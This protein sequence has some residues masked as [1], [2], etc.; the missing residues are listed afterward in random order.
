LRPERVKLVQRIFR[1]HSEGIGDTR[2][3]KILNSEGVPTPSQTGIWQA[4]TIRKLITGKQVLGILET[5]DGQS[6]ENYFPP[7]ITSEEWL[8]ANVMTGSG[9]ATKSVATPKPLSGLVR[10]SCGATMRQQSRTGRL[11]KDGT[12]N[13]W[14]YFVCSKASSGAG[15]IFVGIPQDEVLKR[16]EEELPWIL[17]S[18]LEWDDNTTEIEKFKHILSMAEE[19]ATRAYDAFK[20]ARTPLAR[21]RLADAE[22]EVEQ[23]KKEVEKLQQAGSSIGNNLIRTLLKEPRVKDN[24]WW[25]QLAKSVTIDTI[26]KTLDVN[27]H[28][29]KKFSMFVDPMK[30]DGKVIN[31][32]DLWDD[33]KNVLSMMPNKT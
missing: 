10:C 4:S 19:D 30:Q 24:S 29:G 12:R 27:F 31:G 11:K 22:S 26:L 15:C 21:S 33:I 9:R 16:L 8:A 13:R 6:H 17:H 32:A 23:L 3:V 20:V 7:I 5:A 28:N 25:R 1:L 14:D 18:A 2:I